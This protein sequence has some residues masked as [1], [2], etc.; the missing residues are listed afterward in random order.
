MRV[1]FFMIIA[2]V[3]ISHSLFAE[4]EDT[5]RVRFRNQL[6]FGFTS[7][8]L[9]NELR[10]DVPYASDNVSLAFSERFET[11]LYPFTPGKFYTGLNAKI[12]RDDNCSQSIGGEIQI[13]S[14]TPENSFTR[15]AWG[16]SDKKDLVLKTDRKIAYNYIF[17]LGYD[18]DLHWYMNVE[19]LSMLWPFV[20]S[21]QQNGRSDYEFVIGWHDLFP[22]LLKFKMTKRSMDASIPEAGNTGK[23]DHYIF[24][25]YRSYIHLQYYG[26]IFDASI[27]YLG[28]REYFALASYHAESLVADEYLAINKYKGI[29]AT[30]SY[31]NIAE[32]KLSINSEFDVYKKV[33]SNRVI[34]YLQLGS[35]FLF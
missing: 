30:C 14:G 35:S 17:Q 7:S 13:G 18:N 8:K 3:L 15:I 19:D 11:Y 27:G 16:L 21:S 26:E 12:I 5:S 25:Y 24:L 33:S 10:R 2:V 4:P 29:G 31:K 28:Y 34:I 20:N 6:F 22:V 23:P 9:D 32:K 1:R